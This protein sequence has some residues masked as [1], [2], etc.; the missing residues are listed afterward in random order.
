[1]GEKRPHV[2]EQPGVRGKVRTRR[3]PDGAL[4]HLDHARHVA[5]SRNLTVRERQ[6]FVLEVDG[7]FLV[8]HCM[9]QAGTEQLDERLH[10]RGFSRA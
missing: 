4:I 7:N 1:L 9:A 2:V 5:G 8:H 10:Q 3:A 6:R